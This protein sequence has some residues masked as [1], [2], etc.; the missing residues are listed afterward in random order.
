MN[1]TANNEVLAHHLLRVAG[2][3]RG[4]NA[5]ELIGLLK[6]AAAA[7]SPPALDAPAVGAMDRS[8]PPK[9][10]LQ[11]DTLGD[12]DD[13]SEPIPREAWD[14]MSWHY[15]PIGGQE[16]VYI[17]ADLAHPNAAPCDAQGA[18]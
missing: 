8:A 7:L 15:E 16:V 18:E 13:R 5:Q 6:R 17:R 2:E 14:E 9:V 3:L 11:V 12:D 10:W 1:M 4:D